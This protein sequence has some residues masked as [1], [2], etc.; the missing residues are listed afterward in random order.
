MM[1]LKKIIP[2]ICLIMVVGFNLHTKGQDMPDIYPVTPDQAAFSKYLDIPMNYSSGIAQIDIPLYQIKEFDIPISLNYFSR[3]IKVGELASSVG[4]GW[5]ITGAYSISRQINDLPDDSVYG[6]LR[7]N[8]CK[9]KTLLNYDYIPKDSPCIGRET[10]TTIGSNEL[11][12]EADL[13]YYSLP[14]YSGKFFFNQETK[15]ILL[16]DKSHN[17]KIESLF[18]DQYYNSMIKGFKLTDPVGNQF[19]YGVVEQND[20]SIR[21]DLGTNSYV[22][23]KCGLQSSSSENSLYSSAWKLLKIKYYNGK[24]VVYSYKKSSLTYYTRTSDGYRGGMCNSDNLTDVVNVT[25]TNG[26]EYILDK[27]TFSN[28][29]IQYIYDT[30]RKDINQGVKLNRI[31]ISN[32]QDVIKRFDFNYSYFESDTTQ[33]TLFKYYFPL[34]KGDKRLKL[35]SITQTGLNGQ[36]L[37]PYTFKYNESYRLPNRSATSVDLWGYFNND[38][39]DSY[40]IVNSDCSVDANAVKSGVLEEI[41]Y[42]TGGKTVLE[43]EVNQA[44]KP[45][46]F[47]KIYTVYQ[48]TD[49]STTYYDTQS[50]VND[51]AFRCENAYC[52]EFQIEDKETQDSSGRKWL[53]PVDTDGEYLNQVQFNFTSTGDCIPNVASTQCDYKAYLIAVD[54]NRTLPIYT[55]NT[56]QTIGSSLNLKKGNYTLLVTGPIN[57]NPF[58]NQTGDVG[59]NFSFTIRWK[60]RKSIEIHEET[61]Q[62]MINVGGLRVKRMTFEDG[63][64]S[65]SKEFNYHNSG[66]IEVM[67]RYINLVNRKLSTGYETRLLL[68]GRYKNTY[69]PEIKIAGENLIYTHVS[70]YNK[71]G[72]IGREDYKYLYIPSKISLNGGNPSLIPFY[73]FPYPIP[74][75]NSN[76]NGKL[77]EKN[78]FDTNNRLIEQ[79]RKTYEIPNH[80]NYIGGQTDEDPNL[81]PHYDHV[82]SIIISNKLFENKYQEFIDAEDT[83]ID[84]HES[85]YYALPTYNRS[86]YYTEALVKEDKEGIVYQTDYS[87]DDDKA[88]VTSQT[89]LFIRL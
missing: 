81:N 18:E 22:Y 31:E 56:W 33:N 60:V 27:I 8:T 19:Y 86:E 64:G 59:A 49:T 71:K 55:T 39:N 58:D 78:T 88:L 13:F 4:L 70:V 32:N 51:G 61:E 67:P 48:P 82:P 36:Q 79:T 83:N 69:S 5:S 28:G 63:E 47:E 40:F 46:D 12:L 23:S 75:D 43:Y 29:K 20:E 21:D 76:Q 24:E 77:I 38:A 7:E 44:K 84:G 45:T 37:P 74:N 2:C 15:E 41:Q 16:A 66:I 73:Q 3:G 42:P 11:D 50:L 89:Y 68:A 57:D 14:G 87:H 53:T 72:E 54:E 1:N 65:F 25:K 10:Q 34:A 6:Y 26:Y 85:F 17:I 35:V 9:I 62:D 30:D 80:M 52:V